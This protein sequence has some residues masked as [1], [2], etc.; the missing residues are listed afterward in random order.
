MALQLIIG[1]GIAGLAAAWE[2]VRSGAEVVLVEASAEFG[3]KVRTE[4]VAGLL[5]EEGPDSFVAY[6]PAALQLID[7]LGMSDELISVGTNRTVHLRSRGQLLPLPAGMGMVLPSRLGPFLSTRILRWPDKL[8]AALDLVLPRRLGAD[9]VSIGAFLRARLGDGIVRRF[10]DPMLGGI[11]GAGVDELSL[12][13]VLPILREH[14]GAYR[15]LLIASLAQGR[16]AARSAGGATRGPSSPFRSLRGGMGSLPERLV[17]ALRAGG[18]DLRTGVAVTA[19]RRVGGLT[20]A[21][22]SDGSTLTVDAVVLAGGVRSSADLLAD[23]VPDAAAALRRVPLSGST[24]VTLAYPKAAFRE[25]MTSHGW[26]EADP[27]PV[28]GITISSAKWAGRA[29]EGT[30]LV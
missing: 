28:S 16:R 1:G 2:A 6:R 13:A 24:V 14:E 9:D 11:Y 5:I 23:E 25:S 21:T 3:G 18:A 19:L 4:Q 7:E 8:R 26:L 20:E 12:D 27:A 30:V 10:A 29:P 17:E 15:S 22:L